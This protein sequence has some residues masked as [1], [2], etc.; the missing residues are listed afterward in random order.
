ME[1]CIFCD[2]IA[3]NIPS[4]TIYEDDIVKVI[5]NINPEENGDLLILTKKHFTNALETDEKTLTHINKVIK[6]MSASLTENLNATGITIST[7]TGSNQ[8]IKH[9]HYHITP[10]Y[11]NKNP[12]VDIAIIYDKLI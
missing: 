9:T 8:E 6:S 7:N 3:G 10:G 12:L 1:N 4:K 5:M 2:I 11:E